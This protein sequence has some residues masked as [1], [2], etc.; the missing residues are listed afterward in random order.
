MTGSSAER[1][2]RERMVYSAAQLIRRNGVAATGMRDVVAH[3]DAPRGSLQ[4][5]FPGGKDQLMAEAAQWGGRYAAKQVTRFVATLAEP[6]PGEL[7]AAM[8]RQW[9]DEFETDG[10]VAGCPVAA[11][12]VD[13][14][15]SNATVRR[16]ASDAFAAWQNAVASALREMRVPYRRAESLAALM[17]SAIEG[18]IV[19]ARSERDVRALDVVVTE[20]RPL[21]DAAVAERSAH[22]A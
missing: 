11:S 2:P 19:M 18:A 14:S 12:V 7:F 22:R 6:T 13:C 5:Y 3:A 21:L 4:H 10:F 9:R 17:I 1:A 16:A 20:L 8:A 15:A